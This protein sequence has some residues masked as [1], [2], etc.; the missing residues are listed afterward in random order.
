MVRIRS[1]DLKDLNFRVLEGCIAIF[2]I[3]PKFSKDEIVNVLV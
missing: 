3:V 1:N 2:C